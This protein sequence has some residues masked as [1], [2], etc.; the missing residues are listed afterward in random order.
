M[1]LSGP[2]LGPQEGQRGEKEAEQ[3]TW[4]VGKP[5]QEEGRK[6]FL[7]GPAA[8]PPSSQ[9]RESWFSAKKGETRDWTKVEMM[10]GFPGD[11]VGKES[12]CNAGDPGSTPGLGGSLGEGNGYPFQYS[13]LGKPTDRGAWWL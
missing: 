4:A 8:K 10:R 2:R 12:T 9:G 5:A 11:S 7:D 1:A 6:G 13:C 3:R